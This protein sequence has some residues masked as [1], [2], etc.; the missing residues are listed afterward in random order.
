ME[1]VGIRVAERADYGVRLGTLLVFA[2][3]LPG[4]V[5]SITY[6]MLFGL[7]FFQASL[8]SLVAYIFFF[9]FLANVVG[10]FID[11]VFYRN[12]YPKIYSR[13]LPDRKPLSFEYFPRRVYTISDPVKR[14][15]AE[16]HFAWFCFMFNSGTVI[17]G[18]SILN[19]ASSNINYINS[20]FFL[21]ISAFCFYL[22]NFHARTALHLA[23]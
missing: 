4:L 5:A 22:A 23:M 13:L 16:Y 7:D 15:A 12:V 18:L 1:P 3:V 21:A 2:L 17:T 10:H 8:W 11:L 19:L 14:G 9:G 6:G 20:L